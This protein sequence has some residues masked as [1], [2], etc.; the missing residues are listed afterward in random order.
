MRA[1]PAANG[2]CESKIWIRRAKSP[3]APTQIIAT[4]DAFGFEWTESI[5]RQSSAPRCL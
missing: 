1:A 2:C 5:V 4:L 3:A